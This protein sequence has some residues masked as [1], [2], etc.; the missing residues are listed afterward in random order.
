ML[1]HLKR[2]CYIF[3]SGVV[4]GN[5]KLLDM[6]GTHTFPDSSSL[7]QFFLFLY[8]SSLN[9]WKQSQCEEFQLFK[10]SAVEITLKGT[11]IYR[12]LLLCYL[13][14]KW[15]LH[16]CRFGPLSKEIYLS[17]ECKGNT[18]QS[19]GCISAGRWVKCANQC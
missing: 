6:A 10:L 2:Q 4:G 11:S 14:I 18:T 5:L 9:V 16:L 3:I 1:A 8:I 13:S 7:Y 19:E 12:N 15:Y 17:P